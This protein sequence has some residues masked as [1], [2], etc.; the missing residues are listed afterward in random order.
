M[1]LEIGLHFVVVVVATSFTQ[2]AVKV[3]GLLSVM[4][5]VTG[6]QKQKR[7]WVM[8][9]AEELEQM[10]ELD[11]QERKEVIK[12]SLAKYE[13]M[14]SKLA[15]LRADKKTKIDALT[16]PLPPDIIQAIDDIEEEYEPKLAVGMFSLER[17]EIELREMVK[18][19]PEGTPSIK[20]DLFTLQRSKTGRN[21]EIEA[22]LKIVSDMTKTGDP[23]LVGYA[24]A[25]SALISEAKPVA[26]IVQGGK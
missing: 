10:K 22:L 9:N 15:L 16:P 20:G 5:A 13:D 21:I 25:I 6:T 24:M 26:K 18:L 7:R 12:A 8:F 17:I 19:L 11:L 4:L 14:Q 23:I 1:W 3:L 2:S